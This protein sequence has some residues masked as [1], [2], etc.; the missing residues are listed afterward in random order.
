M[1]VGVPENDVFAA[2][3][4]VL[5]RGE[6]PTVERVRQELGRGS[7]ARVA[8][9]LDHWWG[10]LAARLS[11]ET[12]LPNLPAEIS[13]AFTDV[14]QQA[15][16]LGQDEAEQSLHEQRQL[17]ADERVQVAAVE[18]L[19]RQE[20][21]SHRQ[22]A[23][24]AVAAQHAAETRLADLQ[25]LLEQHLQS[26]ENLSQQRDLSKSDHDGARSRIQELERLLLTDRAAAER[27]RK[28][29]EEYARSVEERAHREVDR[30][31]EEIK[32]MSVQLKQAA[33]HSA[34]LQQ[35]LD[36]TLTALNELQPR[37][38]TQSALA[39]QGARQIASLEVKLASQELLLAEAQKAAAAQQARADTLEAH[40]RNP[41]RLRKPRK[42][43]TSS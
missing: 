3:D 24:S 33:K 30:T 13:Q 43:P 6:R 21:A 8:S 29:Q 42:T 22:Q 27:S 41:V 36:A 20:A 4:A 14:W 23:A 10:M 12:R 5:A 38:A 34:Q 35:R 17:L 7:P 11:A 39:E 19:A 18:N 37:M 15:V 1:A 26:I 31:R 9:L 25:R 40:L 28:A 2:A 32:G 16:R